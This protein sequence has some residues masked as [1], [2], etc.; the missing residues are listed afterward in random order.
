MPL[1]RFENGRV[2]TVSVLHSTPPPPLL[3]SFFNRLVILFETG[4]GIGNAFGVASYLESTSPASVE[5][6]AGDIFGILS[7]MAR[8]PYLPVRQQPSGNYS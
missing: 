2:V 7:R 5:D 6:G 1:T 3:T 4:V 8:M